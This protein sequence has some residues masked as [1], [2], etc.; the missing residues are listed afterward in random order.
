MLLRDVPILSS[1]T[2][3]CSSTSSSRSW[4]SRSLVA[5]A[6][7][8]AGSFQ[9]LR[10]FRTAA[11]T[12]GLEG[13]HVGADSD[14]H[15]SIASATARSNRVVIFIAFG[16]PGTVLTG[17]PMRSTS[18]ASSVATPSAGRFAMVS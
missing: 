9:V 13:M 6:S 5:A 18:P 7:Y 10:G 15:G 1:A 2:R 16:W 3:L 14:P 11:G 17:T 8:A 4:V 12:P